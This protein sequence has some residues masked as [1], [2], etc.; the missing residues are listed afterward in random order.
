MEGTSQALLGAIHQI[1]IAMCLEL[2]ET[3]ASRNVFDKI[4]QKKKRMLLCEIQ[5]FIGL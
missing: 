3:G 1:N 4:Y 2:G 5:K